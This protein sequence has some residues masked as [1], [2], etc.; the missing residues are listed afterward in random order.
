MNYLVSVEIPI[1]NAEST[2]RRCVDS[3]LEQTYR[4]LEIILVNDG[5][6]DSSEKICDEYSS[7]DSRIIVIHKE[8]EGIVSTRKNAAKVMTGEYVA[9]LDADD[10]MEKDCIEN[11]VKKQSESDGDIVCASYYLNLGDEQRLVNNG[12]NS[13]IYSP[14]EICEKM[15]F[16]SDFQ[17]GI[18]PHLWNKLVDKNLYVSRQLGL[19]NQIVAG[20]DAAVLY[21]LILQSKKVCITEIAGYHYVQ[22]SGSITKRRETN[23]YNRIK[24]LF[25]Q[26][27]KDITEFWIGNNKEDAKKNVKRFINCISLFRCLEFVDDSSDGYYLKPWNGI[28]AEDRV[29]VYGAGGCGTEVYRYLKDKCKISI[30]L[31]IDKNSNYYQKRGLPVSD[32]GSIR[33][34]KYD[35]VIISHTEKRI[36]NQMMNYLLEQG[37]NRNKIC[38]INDTYYQGD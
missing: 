38:Y 37:V 28:Q 6:T 32:I 22:T 8:H 21:P 9:F 1:Y 33:N 15:I 7:V 10:W 19:D 12:L 29:V 35:K 17:Y 20:D 5:S 31:W 36:A 24:L 3:V 34:A 30:V 25:N 18:H 27:E 4:N 13:G 11:L 2:L 16:I 26:M 23:E 14:S